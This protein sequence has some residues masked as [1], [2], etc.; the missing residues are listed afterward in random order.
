MI[1]SCERPVLLGFLLAQERKIRKLSQ[2]QAG[3]LLDL[4][5]SGFSRLETGGTSLPALQLRTLEAAW[6]L[7]PGAFFARLA[8]AEATLLN[9]H[10]VRTYDALPDGCA[11]CGPA[12]LRRLLTPQAEESP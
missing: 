5:A 2:T 12:I 1:L 3:R 4:A 10:E 6:A 9:D 8:E 7:P 11:P